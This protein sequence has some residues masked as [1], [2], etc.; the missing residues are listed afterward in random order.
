MI[1]NNAREAATKLNGPYIYGPMA[2]EE[3]FSWP[4]ACTA[5]V[6]NGSWYVGCNEAVP[7]KEDKRIVFE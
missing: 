1:D 6:Q 3:A 4:V 2:K 7:G 5:T